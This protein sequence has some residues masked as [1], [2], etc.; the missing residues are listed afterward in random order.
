PLLHRNADHLRHEPGA[1]R[2][3]AK[4]GVQYPRREQAVHALRRERRRQPIAARDEHVAE[5]LEGAAP[6]EPAY[7][8]AAEERAVPRPQLRAEQA[9]R[10]VRDRE[11]AVEHAPPRIAVTRRIAVELRR[12]RV[13]G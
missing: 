9:E 3:R 11:E 12:I 7:R 10:Q 6:P 13:R 8:L 5:E 4:A 2:V 1:R